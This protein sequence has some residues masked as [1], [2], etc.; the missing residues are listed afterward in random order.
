MHLRPIEIAP[1]LLRDPDRVAV[2]ELKGTQ[3]EVIGAI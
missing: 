3:S 2:R 1:A